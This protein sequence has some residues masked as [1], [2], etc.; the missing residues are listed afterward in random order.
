MIRSSPLSSRLSSPSTRRSSRCFYPTAPP[1]SSRTAWPQTS[2]P[3]SA[4]TATPASPA[5]K[6]SESPEIF[7][8]ETL[9]LIFRESCCG[10][11]FFF[12]YHH[13]FE[14]FETLRSHAAKATVPKVLRCLLRRLCTLLVYVCR[15][16]QPQTEKDCWVDQKFTGRNA[17]VRCA[18][19]SQNWEKKKKNRHRMFSFARKGFLAACSPS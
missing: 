12:Y 19:F 13:Y 18:A 8:Q 1:S 4:L 17:C 16:K 2:T 11:V 6:S 5:L 10:F 9:E 7:S 14:S 3:T 15:R